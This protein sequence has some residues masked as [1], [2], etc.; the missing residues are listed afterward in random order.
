MHIFLISEM[1][2]LLR[3]GT[4]VNNRHWFFGCLE[5]M[6]IVLTKSK[7]DQTYLEYFRCRCVWFW[8]YVIIKLLRMEMGNI[9]KWQQIDQ[10][11]DNS[12]RPSI[13]GLQRRQKIPHREVVLSWSLSKLCTCSFKMD[14]TLTSKTYKIIYTE[15][16]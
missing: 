4:K 2:D 11:A 9:S 14:G 10:R 15:I 16:Q 7:T 1:S 6:S 8:Y 5:I 12:K 3:I 13:R